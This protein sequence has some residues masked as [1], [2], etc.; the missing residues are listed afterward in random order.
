MDM[1]RAD[2][3]VVIT[4]AIEITGEEKRRKGE[5]ECGAACGFGL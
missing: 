2:I 1:D 4:M 3:A 5:V